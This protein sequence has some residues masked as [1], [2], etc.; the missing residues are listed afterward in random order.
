ME[1]ALQKLSK[2]NPRYSQE[3]KKETKREVSGGGEGGEERK[4]KTKKIQEK[5][6]KEAKKKKNL[7]RSKRK[8]RKRNRH[9][10]IF[11][12]SRM[13]LIQKLFHLVNSK[14][15]TSFSDTY[16]WGFFSFA[17]FAISFLP[18][19]PSH[20]LSPT[21]PSFH[22]PFSSFALYF[23]FPPLLKRLFEGKMEDVEIMQIL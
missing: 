20:T 18:F 13:S 19:L 4:R 5:K 6:W 23:F 16:F 11:I 17:S 14:S 2:E 15:R 22:F 12:Y 3:K 7:F 9:F 10:L 21:S 8:K 1:R